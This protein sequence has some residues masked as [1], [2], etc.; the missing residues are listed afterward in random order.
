MRIEMNIEGVIPAKKQDETP[1]PE[2]RRFPGKETI[3]DNT[4]LK[5]SNPIIQNQSHARSLIDAMVI[6]QMA[7]SLVHK[8]IQISSRLKNVAMEAITSGKTK[9]DE[10]RIALSETRN[11]FNKMNESF[12]PAVTDF[13]TAY[14]PEVQQ[15]K[16]ITIELPQ[17]KKEVDLLNEF[18]NELSSGIKPDLNKIEIIS[19][20][21]QEKTSSIDTT[22]NQ[23][24]IS[25]GTE[26]K[27]YNESFNTDY[28]DLVKKMKSQILEIPDNAFISQGNLNPEM[29][30]SLFHNEKL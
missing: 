22:I 10:L 29:A 20:S 23:L 13:S 17:L 7:Q 19:N 26:N 6:S 18:E 11:S 1:S 9:G 21:L 4:Y 28:P 27:D 15:G 8:A 5:Q 12:I 30:K 25:L 3:T 16:R 2:L 24:G 14:S